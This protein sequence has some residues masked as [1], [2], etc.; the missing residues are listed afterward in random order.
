MGAFVEPSYFRIFDYNW[1]WAGQ[2][3]L[4]PA[5]YGGRQC[6]TGTERNFGTTTGISR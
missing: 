2:T 5:Q 4:S 3:D 6:R 1:I